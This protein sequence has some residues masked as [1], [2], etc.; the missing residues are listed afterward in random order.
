MMKVITCGTAHWTMKHSWIKT[1]Q[2]TTQKGIRIISYEEDHGLTTSLNNRFVIPI[3][4]TG[5][6]RVE[7]RWFCQRSSGSFMNNSFV[8]SAMKH[9]VVHWLGILMFV[10]FIFCLVPNTALRWPFREIS[11]HCLTN[12]LFMEYHTFRCINILACTYPG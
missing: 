8:F 2:R 3:I 7:T 9:W 11:V 1:W 12:W 5:I 4:C 10:I 6:Q